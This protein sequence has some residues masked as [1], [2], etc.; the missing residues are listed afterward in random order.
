[1]ILSEF[2]AGW[3]ILLRERRRLWPLC[4][5]IV[6][7]SVA[8][9]RLGFLWWILEPII[10]AAI[11]YFVVVV[12][13]RR[14]GPN[15]YF[16]LISGLFAWQVFAYTLNTV[17]GSLSQLQ[18]FLK[19]GVFHPIVAVTAPALVGLLYGA[20]AFLI[21]A[22]L[23]PFAWGTHGLFLPVAVLAHVL[24]GYVLG[25]PLSMLNLFFA[26]TRRIVGYLL[27]LGWFATPI[28][29]PI[30]RVLESGALG[31]PLKSFYL[32]NPMVHTV[33]FFRY[34]FDGHLPLPIVG[35]VSVFVG[36]ALLLPLSIGFLL[37]HR[38]RV[39]KA[40]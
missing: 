19:Q 39:M 25:V 40:L 11:F 23:S 16:H 36:A 1:M 13:W 3:R 20:I 15:F 33:T 32:L 12:M 22:A 38:N 31:E 29:Y 6:T 4:A 34:C 21:A 5:F 9:Q 8:G 24:L 28:L 26:D 2:V 14:G 35:F 10:I 18:A 30:E 37:R 7:K 17:T 27:R